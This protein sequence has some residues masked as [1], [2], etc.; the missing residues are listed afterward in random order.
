MA[1]KLIRIGRVSSIDYDAG[2]ISVTYPDLDD[3]TSDYLS[4]VSCND[5]YKMPKIGDEVLT[6]HLPSGQARGVVIGKYWNLTNIPAE[7]GAD[8]YRKELGHTQGQ[9]Y[10]SYKDEG[11]LKIHAPEI[12]LETPDGS[13]SLTELLAALS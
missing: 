10:L 1:D 11:T 3:A 9:A 5:E 8:V 7:T 2:M 4:V 12:V 6:V 13:I